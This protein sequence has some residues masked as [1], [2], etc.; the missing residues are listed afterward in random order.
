M[1]SAQTYYRNLGLAGGSLWLIEVGMGFALW[2]LITIHSGLAT[3]LLA[4]L[5]IAAVTLLVF[6]IRLILIARRQTHLPADDPSRQRNIWRRFALIFAAEAVGC[7][8][9]AAVCLTTHHWKWIVP[10]QLVIVGLHFLPLARLFHVPRYNLLG[11]LFC[12]I[13]VATMLLTASSA[14][15]GH[16]FTWIAVPSLGCG[17]AALVTG[18]AGLDEVQRSL[19][20][21]TTQMPVRA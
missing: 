10:L 17:V 5:A 12:A 15:I 6:G 16:A 21:S 18:A 4:L 3:V 14:H 13:P 7:G 9:V 19:Y 8:A 11:A 20:N 1:I 2:S